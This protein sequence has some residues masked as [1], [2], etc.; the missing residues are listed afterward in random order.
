MPTLATDPEQVEQTNEF[1]TLTTSGMGMVQRRN[2][3]PSGRKNRT[4]WRISWGTA[5]AAERDTLITFIRAVNGGGSFTW[6]P[7]GGSSG[8]YRLI[9]SSNSVSFMSD[10]SHQI[11]LIIEEV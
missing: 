2:V 3:Y 10:A 6:T 1:R 5:T 11:E 4:R 8:T 9:H 7:P